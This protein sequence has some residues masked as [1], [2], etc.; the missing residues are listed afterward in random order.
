[1][2]HNNMTFEKLKTVLPNPNQENKQKNSIDKA[3]EIDKDFNLEKT[4]VIAIVSCD[5][6]AVPR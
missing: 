1:M 2:K 4:K 3:R 5:N 6:C